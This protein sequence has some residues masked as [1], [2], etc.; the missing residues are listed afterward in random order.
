MTYLTYACEATRYCWY[1]QRYDARTGAVYCS[2]CGRFL[3][4]TPKPKWLPRG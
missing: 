1:R 4:N 3:R 2:D